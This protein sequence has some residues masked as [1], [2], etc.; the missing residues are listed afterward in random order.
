MN[1]LVISFAAGT[2]L[3]IALYGQ[4]LSAAE[5]TLIFLR[6]IP[7]GVTSE[8]RDI[9]DIKEASPVPTSSDVPYQTIILEKMWPTD[10]MAD[11]LGYLQSR[12][13]EHFGGET[14]YFEIGPGDILGLAH[15]PEWTQS[16]YRFKSSSGVTGTLWLSIGTD[17]FR[18][19]D[20]PEKE[21]SEVNKVSRQAK[22]A[23]QNFLFPMHS[24]L[25]QTIGRLSLDIRIPIRNELALVIVSGIRD[26]GTAFCC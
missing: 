15:E 23:W 21:E 1:R 19:F 17:L 20:L 6:D 3:F 2:V 18:I 12:L 10:D 16:T 5:F 7:E 24:A 25:D 11:S 26:G 13:Q 14:E 22:I 9:S 4:S 8:T